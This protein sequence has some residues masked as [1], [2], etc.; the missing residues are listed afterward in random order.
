MAARLDS[1][2]QLGKAVLSSSGLWGLI[3]VSVLIGLVLRALHSFLRLRHVPGPILASLSDYSRVS[4][5]RTT[6]AHLVHQELHNKYGNIVRMGPNMVSIGNPSAV[7]LLYP[8][9]RGFLKVYSGC[10]RV[11]FMLLTSVSKQGDFYTPLR[12]YS[13]VG[14][15][16]P[17]VFT[18]L[19]ED[20]HSKLKR[21][22]AQIFSQSNVVTFEN[23]VDDVLQIISDQLDARFVKNS[24]TFNL[25]EWLQYFAFD[26][27]GTL[28]FSKRYGFLERG[29]DTGN[30]L[31]AIWQFMKQAA[32][33]SSILFHF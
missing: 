29:E 18:S 13:R 27:M 6:K 28:S 22:I 14:G 20:M 12:P 4:W 19:D 31:D 11:A 1:P 23:L 30:K 10:V 26:V 25:G 16:L 21:P 15:A 2:I 5:V 3:L 17:A 24:E 33:V 9:R 7:P 32:P 8:M